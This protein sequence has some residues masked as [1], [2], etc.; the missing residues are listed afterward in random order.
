LDLLE[1]PGVVRAT[2]EAFARGPVHL[3][4]FAYAAGGAREWRL[5]GSMNALVGA[6]PKEL[7]KSISLLLSPASPTTPAEFRQPAKT[8][9][10]KAMPEGRG[11]RAGDVARN[12]VPV[13][14]V[15]YQAAQYLG[16]RFAAEAWAAQA[17]APVV[18]ANMAGITRSRSTEHPLFTAAFS[19]AHHLGV[20]IFEP[21]L[22]T[23]LS[24]WLML[25]DLF[26]SQTT[27]L[28]DKQVHGGVLGLPISLNRAISAAA[29]VGLAR[30]PRL[31]GSVL[32]G[33]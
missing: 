18:S 6:I 26:A 20:R 3:G 1:S 30:H 28:F 13:Q 27:K 22:T 16:K 11:G 23:K 9:V 19:G 33:R 14:G 31:L 15:S 32:R 21:E 4:L 29:T 7:V 12:V 24:A 8:T 10:L 17:G 25:H 5:C 2:I